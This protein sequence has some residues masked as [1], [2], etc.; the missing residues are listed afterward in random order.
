[1]DKA[2]FQE[3]LKRVKQE[4]NPKLTQEQKAELVLLHVQRDTTDSSNIEPRKT[5]Q[6]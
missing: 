6:E 1:M 5:A 4:Q 2:E 3:I